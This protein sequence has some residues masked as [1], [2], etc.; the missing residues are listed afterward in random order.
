MRTIV[1][2]NRK[3]GVG[4][5][6]TVIN[7]AAYL[8]KRG[9]RVLIVDADSQHDVT[10]FFRVSNDTGDLALVLKT[11]PQKVDDRFVC[12]I[13]GTDIPGLDLLPASDELVDLELGAITGVQA[14]PAS[15]RELLLTLAETQEHAYDIVLIDCPPSFSPSCSAALLAADEVLIP[16]KLDFFSIKGMRTLM[17]QLQNV[18]KVNKRLRLLG[19]LPTMYRETPH[20][21]QALKQLA[22]A[23]IPMVHPF[24]PRSEKVDEM[25]YHGE[26]LTTYSPKSGPGKA[27][28]LLASKLTGGDEA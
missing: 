22:A 14:F 13:Y 8:V 4:K 25:T 26:P 19:V 21:S 7:L 15:L 12:C 17:Q 6:T 10:D 24:I 3:G 9:K 18:R 5:T 28:K 2:L 11:P 1:I 23:N 27:Y 16:M 20:T